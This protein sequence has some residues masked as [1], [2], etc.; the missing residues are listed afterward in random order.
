ME[1][2]YSWKYIHSKETAVCPQRKNHSEVSY[3]SMQL[4]LGLASLSF[5]P[6][7]QPLMSKHFCGAIR[8]TLVFLLHSDSDSARY[9]RFLALVHLTLRTYLLKF[10][11]WV[12]LWL[13]DPQLAPTLPPWQ[14][15]WHPVRFPSLDLC[16]L[17]SLYDSA[18]TSCLTASDFS[19]DV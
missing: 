13:L 3:A 4:C 6:W 10:L 16:L 11:P 7:L 19:K 8:L 12:T 5:S 17:N 9:S 14:S 1:R 15:P 2:Y 18:L